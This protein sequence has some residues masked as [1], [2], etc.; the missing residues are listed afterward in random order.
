MF[1][2]PKRIKAMTQ[3]RTVT[4]GLVAIVVS[5]AIAAANQKA[6][7]R[8]FWSDEKIRAF[9]S[10]DKIERAEAEVKKTLEELETLYKCYLD[11]RS[12]NVASLKKKLSAA[13]SDLDFIFAT[14]DGVTGDSE[15]KKTRKRLV[16]IFKSHTA[17]VDVI[18]EV[19]LS[20]E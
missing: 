15:V 18:V 20:K 17:K 9:S 6:L 10:L 5:V 16:Q 12:S 2:V 14:L 7:A 13:S 8:L 3:Q 19:V 1:Q 4:I 11:D